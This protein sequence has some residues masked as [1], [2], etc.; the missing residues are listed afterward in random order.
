M[1]EFP[2][3]IFYVHDSLM[4]LQILWSNTNQCQYNS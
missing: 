3:H 2:N 1:K 4:K